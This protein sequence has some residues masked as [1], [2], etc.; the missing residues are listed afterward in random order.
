MRGYCTFLFLLYITVNRPWA[1]VIRTDSAGM[2]RLSEFTL[3]TYRPEPARETSIHIESLRPDSLSRYGNMNLTDLLT[4]VPGVQMLSTGPSVTKPVIRGLYGNRVMVLLSGLRFDNQQ[5]QEEHGLGLSDIGVS[6]IELVKGPMSVL[7]GSE[8]MG[9]IINLIDEEKPAAGTAESNIVL[10]FFTNTLGGTLQGGY[11]QNKG[12]NWFS[13]RVGADSHGDYSDGLNRRVLNSRSDGYYLKAA[14]GITTKKVETTV[15]YLGSYNRFGFI[16]NDA[17]EFVIADAR[18]SRNLGS[19]P[20]HM[21][22]LN[23]LSAENTFHLKNGSKL[24]LNAGFQS[25]SR[26]ENE[27]G[28]AISLNM[29]LITLQYLLKWESKRF[30]N[31][32][33]ILS[34]LGSYENNQ[35]YGARKIVPDASLQEA[36]VSAYMETRAGTY[37]VFENGIGAG[38]KLILTQF[39]PGVNGPGKEVQPFTKFSGYYNAFTGIS[40]FPG[41]NLTAKFNASTGVRIPNLAELSSNGLHEG[42]YTFEIGNPG[43]KNEYL[44]AGNLFVA[45]TSKYIDVFVSPFVNRFLNY[46]WLAPT[47]EEW[48][49]FPVFRYKQQHA[50]QYGSEAGLTLKPFKNLQI[51]GSWSGMV[52]KTDDGRYTPYIPAQK[53]MP[54]VRYGISLKNAGKLSVYTGADVLAAQFNVYPGEPSTPSYALWNGGISYSA[55]KGNVS[56][57]IQLSGQNLLNTAYTD[58][59][60]RFKYFGILNMGR[61]IS[62]KIQMRIHHTIGKKS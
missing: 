12:K 49:G 53:I 27:G 57:D 33:F 28:G 42:V 62:M 52:S 59:L 58:H 40:I 35:N 45:Y 38:Q 44:V 60:S 56:W 47:S 41:K 43:L 46:V 24:F 1:Q 2:F 21:V 4:K 39:T 16:F 23:L 25:N 8:A 36:N 55:K 19:N 61:N 31:S 34:H 37:C 26:M 11:K 13:I 50:L 20:T 17:Q 7:Y 32:R 48:F 51:S 54:D 29:H 3:T 6:R 5:W 18:W 22:M 30:G 10:K 9:G 15:R 14:W